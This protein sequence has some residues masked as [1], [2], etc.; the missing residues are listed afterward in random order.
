MAGV[1][2]LSATLWRDNAD[3]TAA[4]L[5]HPFVLGLADGSLAPERFAAFIAQDAFFL[6]A[7][8]RAYALALA[9]CPDRVGLGAF[10][11]LLAGVR[12]EL[13]LHAAYADRL[14]INL[15]TV[16]PAPA[17]LAYTDFLLATAAVGGTSAACVA[18]TPC[19]RLYAHIGQSLAAEPSAET[20]RE[21]IDT[22]ADPSFDA[23]AR[24]LEELLDR[25]ATGTERSQQIYRRAMQLELDF[26][27]AALS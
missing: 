13:T 1:I 25:Y 21:W 17:T 12:Q 22:Y 18:M 5:Q 4:T 8:A 24:T 3:L 15:T 14:G 7:F 6:D 9:A 16:T 23:L 11:D 26:F 27:T 20:Y 2:P 19:M 10:A